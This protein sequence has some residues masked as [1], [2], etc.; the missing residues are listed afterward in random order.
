MTFTAL[1]YSLLHG[2]AAFIVWYYLNTIYSRRKYDRAIRKINREQYPLHGVVLFWN[3][4]TYDS[5]A[6]R[7]YANVASLD[8]YQLLI[9]HWQKSRYPPAAGWVS[10]V[11]LAA[12]APAEDWPEVMETEQ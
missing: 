7:L 11:H 12:P 9:D 6:E 4:E 3:W 5:A 1:L 8:D 2:V 10:F